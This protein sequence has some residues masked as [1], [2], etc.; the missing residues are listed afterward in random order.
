MQFFAYLGFAIVILTGLVLLQ[1]RLS[2]ID[3]RWVG[4]ILPIL[5]FCFASLVV[6]AVA[7]DQYYGLPVVPIALGFFTPPAI[8]LAIY[9]SRRQKVKGAGL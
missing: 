1:M 6:W 7:C 5:T 8:L 9:I 3:S 4:L 2:E